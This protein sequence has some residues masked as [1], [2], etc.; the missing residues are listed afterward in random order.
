M[1]K[2]NL[3]PILIAIAFVM[4]NIFVVGATYVDSSN[5]SI[6]KKTLKEKACGFIGCGGGQQSCADV[7]GTLEG[8][9]PGVIGGSVEVTYYCYQKVSGD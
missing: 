7:S 1:L 9:I 8:G 5:N 6:I 3:R 2:N 4:A